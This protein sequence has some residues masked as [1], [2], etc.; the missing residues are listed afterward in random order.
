[1]IICLGGVAIPTASLK[2][3]NIIINSVL[4]RHYA[5]ITFFDVKNIIMPP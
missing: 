4:S 2:I 3:L 5:K 1:M